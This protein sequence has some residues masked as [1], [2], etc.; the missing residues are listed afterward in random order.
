MRVTFEVD[1]I[2]IM[3]CLVYDCFHDC[4][5]ETDWPQISN[6]LKVPYELANRSDLVCDLTGR[7]TLL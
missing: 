3:Y 5:N 1:K 4:H 6:N 7:D 2:L